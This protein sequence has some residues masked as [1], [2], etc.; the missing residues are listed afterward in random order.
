MRTLKIG[1]AGLLLASL[2]VV[3]LLPVVAGAQ[4]P[5]PELI[6][7]NDTLELTAEHTKLEG[8]SGDS[9]EFEVFIKYTGQEA[10]NFDLAAVG[11]KDWSVAITP[12]YPRDT[13]IKDI[14]LA[15]EIGETV[16]VQV[17]TPYWL[18]VEPGTYDIN[19]EVSAPDL[20]GSLTLQVIIT[21]RYD[22]WLGPSDGLLNTKVQAGRD[23][24]YTVVVRNRGSATINSITFS[25]SK[26]SDWTIQF[27]PD[28]IDALAAGGEQTV[29]V[30]ITPPSKTIAGDY[31][32]T[33]GTSG[34]EAN[35]SSIEVRITVE[36]P[37]LWGWVGVGIIVLVVAGLG[38][39][40][41]RFSRR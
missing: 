24:Y 32:I 17:S 37:S 23:N 9:F 19:L 31:Q 14:R 4:D 18:I 27:N 21:A 16:V 38:F 36:T 28:K 6:S 5:E 41:I 35:A 34:S 2:L 33:L 20:S 22:L 11:P 15:S 26:P 13:K 3:A 1:V 12:S 39:T 10:R 25:R 40:I 7:A 8:I 30:N 29:E